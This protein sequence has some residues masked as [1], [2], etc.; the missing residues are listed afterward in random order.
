M[1]PPLPPSAQSPPAPSSTHSPSKRKLD[2]VSFALIVG[3]VVG[4]GGA[5][6]L[7]AVV[8]GIIYLKTK[9]NAAHSI[10]AHTGKYVV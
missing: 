10:G 7:A 3:F 9:K 6:L 2:G 1:P 4:L 8:C 5:C